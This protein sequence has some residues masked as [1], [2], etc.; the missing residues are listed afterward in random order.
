MHVL[1][2]YR[3]TLFLK[4]TN[5]FQLEGNHNVDERY[6]NNLKESNPDIKVVP[7]IY[8]AASDNEIIKS[9]SD[10]RQVNQIAEDVKKLLM[11]HHENIQFDLF[12]IFYL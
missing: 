9:I 6:I 4:E 10:Q 1:N 11:Y 3:L 5:I 7:R 8:L 12:K 2:F